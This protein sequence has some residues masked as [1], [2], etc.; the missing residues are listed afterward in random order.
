MAGEASRTLTDQVTHLVAGEV[1]SKKYQVSGELGKQIMLPE[2][3]EAVW[4]K[5]LEGCVLL[6]VQTCSPQDWIQARTPQ[7]CKNT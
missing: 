3:V 1:G 5:S 4:K 6:F 2:W 7:D